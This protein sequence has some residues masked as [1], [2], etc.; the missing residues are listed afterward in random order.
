MRA[1]RETDIHT[2]R[3]KSQLRVRQTEM[4]RKKTDWQK[5]KWLN[6]IY[7]QEKGDKDKKTK[8][9]DQKGRLRKTD[10]LDR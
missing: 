6:K 10:R 2:E 9:R 1:E 8:N 5:D 3:K 7:G 4:N